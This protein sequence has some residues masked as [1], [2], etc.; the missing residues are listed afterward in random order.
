MN[1]QHQFAA[2][3]DGSLIST[4]INRLGDGFRVASAERQM[5]VFL[6]KF[7]QEGAEPTSGGPLPDE[8]YHP[9]AGEGDAQFRDQQE[10]IDVH[11]QSRTEGF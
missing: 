3:L 10:D 4:K 6:T 8:D 7:A 1:G 11:G 9:L 5:F 2:Q